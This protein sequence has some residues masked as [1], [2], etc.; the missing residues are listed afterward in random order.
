MLL[1]VISHRRH[2]ILVGP[3]VCDKVC[4]HDILWEPLV[5]ISLNSQLGTVWDKDELIRF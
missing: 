1:P 3:C 2:F 5:G 4:N